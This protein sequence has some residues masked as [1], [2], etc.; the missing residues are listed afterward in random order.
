MDE[1]RQ[2]LAEFGLLFHVTSNERWAGIQQHGFSPEA[3]L[4]HFGNL[5]ENTPFANRGFSCF[6]IPRHLN[7]VCRMLDDGMGGLDDKVLLQV[8]ATIIAPL[9]FQLDLTK[10]EIL[11]EVGNVVPVA[12]VFRAALEKHGYVACFDPIPA[13]QVRFVCTAEEFLYNEPKD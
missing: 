6:S 5:Y 9:D 1:L 2:I 12:N 13:A 4:A 8:P 11:L 7:H 3:A 10:Q